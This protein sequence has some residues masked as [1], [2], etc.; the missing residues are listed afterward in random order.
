MESRVCD[1]DK[2][3]MSKDEEHAKAMA[4][5]VDESTAN[6]KKLEKEHYNKINKT[7]DAGEKAR[8]EAEMRSKAEVEVSELKEKVKLLEAECVKSIGLAREK[9]IQVGKLA[10]QE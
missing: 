10:G 7:K 4:N 8:A 6:Y 1:L 3:L 2:A 5:M 9:G